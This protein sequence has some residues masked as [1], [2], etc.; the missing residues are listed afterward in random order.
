[1]E[2]EETPKSEPPPTLKSP[3][4]KIPTSNLKPIPDW[5]GPGVII[6]DGDG[7]VDL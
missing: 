7:E 5:N 1:M 4:S 2:I 3:I 6:E